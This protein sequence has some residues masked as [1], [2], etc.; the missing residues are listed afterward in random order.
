MI[1]DASTGIHG[2]ADAMRKGAEMLEE[3]SDE[4]AGVYAE[5]TG[6]DK[7]DIRK[8]MKS[9]TWI[10]AKK[11]IEMGFADEIFDTKSKV[12]SILD[13]F[14]PDAALVEKVNS[15]ESSLVD[16]EN[17]VSELTAKIDE[18]EN[19]LASAV[20]E[21]TEAK[22]K[23]D[24]LAEEK[25]QFEAS[26]NGISST[27]VLLSALLLKAT[28]TFCPREPVNLLKTLFEIIQICTLEELNTQE[29]YYQD[30]FDVL[31]TNGLNCR[32]QQSDGKTGKNSA[33]SNKKR[34]ESMKGKN[35]GPRPDVS[36]K[37]KLIHKGKTISEEHKQQISNKLK[38]KTFSEE[39]NR[40]ISEASKGKQ[41]SEQ[42]R[43][44][45]S[46]ARKGKPA[47]NKGIP[48]SEETKQKI[49]ETKLKNSLA[50]K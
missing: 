40:K 9:E 17:K 34:S 25:A 3:I 2:N 11:A 21:L 4:I 43:K 33:E 37:N 7:G 42:H 26:F 44:N 24:K 10:S 1:H 50:K 20:T 19:D 5:K 28:I 12:M 15:L 35:K 30:F 49:K 29:R 38:G 14:K 23:A 32:L 47:W 36:E 27:V 48:R 41:K 45:I 31:G 6:K 18:V 39:R 22:A 8:M 13:K 16:A 46:E